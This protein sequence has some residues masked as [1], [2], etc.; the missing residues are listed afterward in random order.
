MQLL[1]SVTLTVYVPL[2][3]PDITVS[4]TEFDHKYVYEVPPPTAYTVAYP[5]LPPLQFTAEES[6]VNVNRVGG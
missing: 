2:D 1:L 3:N 6:I 4:V 5:S